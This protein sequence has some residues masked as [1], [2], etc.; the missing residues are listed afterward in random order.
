MAP[1]LK[2]GFA[3]TLKCLHSILLI[4]IYVMRLPALHGYKASTEMS[5]IAN[6]NLINGA[7]FGKR[8]LSIKCV[9]SFP[10]QLLSKI[11]LIPRRI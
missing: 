10:L 6:G 2:N 5:K 7:I 1:N 11:F 3:Q 4:V 9:F 8:L